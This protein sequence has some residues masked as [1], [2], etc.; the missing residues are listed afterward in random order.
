MQIVREELGVG[1]AECGGHNDDEKHY[2]KEMCFTA[3]RL[4]LLPNLEMKTAH[5]WVW[6]YLGNGFIL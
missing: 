6:V 4:Y 3:W 2:L 5:D 1:T